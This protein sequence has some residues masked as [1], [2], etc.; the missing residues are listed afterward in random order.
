[1]RA[2]RAGDLADSIPIVHAEPRMVA[3]GI[4]QDTEKGRMRD[5]GLTATSFSREDGGV[6]VMRRFREGGTRGIFFFGL[7]G[8]FFFCCVG[9]GVFSGW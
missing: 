9:L 7:G 8:F 2:N 5:S 4:N 1:M 3:W 6:F